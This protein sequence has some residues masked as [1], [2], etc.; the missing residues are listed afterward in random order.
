MAIKLNGMFRHRRSQDIVHRW[1]GNPLIGIA[2]VPFK[3]N[4]IHNASAVD[5]HDDLL[6]LVTVEHLSGQRCVHVAKAGP[7]GQFEVVAKPLLKPSTQ[8]PYLTHE[9]DGVLDARV[10]FL[11]GVYYIMYNAL[12]E[13]GYRL[14]LAKTQDFKTVE[15]IGLISEPDTKAGVLFPKKIGGRYARLERPSQ[16][17]SIWVSYSDD[18]IYWGSSQRVIGPRGGFWDASRVGAGPTPMAVDAGWLVIYYGAKDTSAGPIYRIGAMLLDHD[19]PTRVIGR[20]GIPILSPREMYERIGD[21]QNL[22]FSTGAFVDEDDQ[23]HIVYGAANSCICMGTTT[24]QD[25]VDH[26]LKAPKEDL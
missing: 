23:L 5:F 20:S 6:L 22:V 9:R 13:H 8:P 25:V 24:V 14:G 12:G 19:D 2:D 26:C 16:G 17:Q 7:S 18:L 1:D 10:T 4:D 15:R 3:C 21:V 11:D